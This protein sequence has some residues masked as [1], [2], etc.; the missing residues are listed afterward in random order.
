MTAASSAPA[1]TV[2]A[3]T[4]GVPRAQ[5]R[6]VE[7][8][9]IPAR[10]ARRILGFFR[11]CKGFRGFECLTLGVSFGAWQPRLRR[12][13]RRSRRSSATAKQ[14]DAAEAAWLAKV[15][16]Y[17]VSGGW[18]ADNYLS[19]AAAI[20]DHCHL[21]RTAATAAVRLA[22]KLLQLPDL[23]AAFA[24][25]DT[26]RAACR[27]RR[28]RLHPP[29]AAEFDQHQPALVPLR[30]QRDPPRPV[31]GGHQDHRHHRR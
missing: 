7:A 15:A 22:V 9:D 17:A 28:P 2:T 24:A 21:T 3:R 25:G 19:A 5:G 23:A 13:N 31:Q 4:E 26:S 6:Q 29:R 12:S 30:G 11:F 18:A 8:R 16:D 10:V 1:P 20:G 14:L 27:S